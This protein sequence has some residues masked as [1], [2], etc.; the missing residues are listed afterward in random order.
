MPITYFSSPVV[1]YLLGIKFGSEAVAILF[2]LQ[3]FHMILPTFSQNI[4][5]S[6]HVCSQLT[7]DLLGPDDGARHWRQVSD[8]AHLA[9]LALRVL[10][11]E[12]VV[13]G[14]DVIFHALDEL[15]LV[16]SNGAPDMGAH[17]EGVEAGENA[18]HL[19]GVLCSSQL[20][21]QAG[22]DPRL[23][24][25]DAFIVALH[26]SFPGLYTLLRNIQAVHLFDVLIGQIDLLN[27][28][29]ISS[30]EENC[31]NLH[32][33]RL[34]RLSSSMLRYGRH[35]ENISNRNRMLIHILP[36]F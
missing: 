1:E 7:V 12:L 33:L 5:H 25:V 11:F 23:H 2:Q 26:G 21:A 28:V 16:L 18:E 15:R 3:S 35:L 10:H 27:G 32:V 34:N 6:L 4:F 30:I 8:V 14:L 17:K 19:V 20:I 24:A 29:G 22:G 36:D 31:S 13:Q 9:G